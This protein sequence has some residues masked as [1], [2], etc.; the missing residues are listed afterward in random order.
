MSNE[1]P[2]ETEKPQA[3]S[4]PTIEEQNAILRAENRFLQEQLS[5]RGLSEPA[6]QAVRF[7]VREVVEQSKPQLPDPVNCSD[8]EYFQ[9][10]D[11]LIKKHNLRRKNYGY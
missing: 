6:E 8:A 1:I 2:Q 9:H 10:R 11:E 7:A 3:D 4:Q 5:E